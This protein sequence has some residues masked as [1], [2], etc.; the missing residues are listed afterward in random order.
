MK[1]FDVLTAP[2]AIEP[3][4]LLE[5]HA[6]YAARVHGDKIDISAVE[7]RLGRSLS[8]E[9]RDYDVVDGVAIISIDGVIA[10]KM[11]MFSAIS[12][13]ASSEIARHSLMAAQAD[14]AVHSIIVSIDS[15][16][17]TVDGT[18]TLGD[19][20]YAARSVKPIVTLGGGVIASAA[21]WIGSAANAVYIAEDTTSVG[22][23]GVVTAHKDISGSET[24]R[25]VKTTEISAGKY[26]RIA[27]AYEPLSEEGRESIQ[28]QLD[29]MYSLF[30]SAVARNRGVD[31][32]VVLDKMADGR[33]FIGN[34]AIEAGLVD[35]VMSLDALIAKLN[36]DRPEYAGN[37]ASRRAL[38]LAS[39]KTTTSK[40]LTMNKE[41]LQAAH[42]AL[43]AELRA[44][45]AATER[46]RIQAIEGQ[47]IPGHEALIT[48]MKFDGKSN[49]GDAAMAVVAAEKS[50]RQAHATASAKEAPK[51]L[52]SPAPPVTTPAAAGEMSREELHKATMEYQ[53][54]HPGTE[55]MAAYKAVGGK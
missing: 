20:V 36:Q 29:Y 8:N 46:E 40:G 35:G 12:G 48:A 18:Q 49:A 30:V 25:G 7:A 10:K 1:I 14:S 51:P 2:W 33:V 47:A 21:Y 4:K 34:Q 23:I 19:A 15:P 26:K 38:A 42:P 53:A 5:L 31:A 22:S 39:T 13:G 45:G 54:K 17:G 24:A 6:I 3:S 41:E 27:S 28:G 43:A 55:Y 52:A 9:Q 37:P 32:S 11:N 50:A 44:E 16:G